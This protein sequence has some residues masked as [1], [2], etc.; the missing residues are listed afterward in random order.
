VASQQDRADIG[1]LAKLFVG[2]SQGEQEDLA[3]VQ[4]LFTRAGI[5]PATSKKL[6]ER[7]IENPQVNLIRLIALQFYFEK[8]SAL[9][10]QARS[11]L[12]DLERQI[13]VA[14]W[15][16]RPDPDEAFDVPMRF[17]RGA[18]S[19]NQKASVDSAITMIDVAAREL[20]VADL[21]GTT[22]LDIG[23]GVKF[24]Q[25]FYGRKI[26]V[27]RYHGVD[28]DPGMIDFLSSAVKDERFSYKHIDVYNARYYNAGKR[29][30]ADTDLGI[31]DETFD[32]ICLFSVFTHLE[33]ADF[34]AML[35]LTRR[36]IAPSGTL[37]FTSFI[38][39]KLSRDFEDKDPEQPLLMALYR[40]AAVREFARA[41]RWS[42]NKIFLPGAQHWVVCTPTDNPPAS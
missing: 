41:A 8:I 13:E 2:S 31:Q 1:S 10:S 9:D 20:G 34:Q 16:P 17:R 30:S 7:S 4:A 32:L 11:A 21:S 15:P 18:F 5:I 14:L 23:C 25:A 40:E 26:P 6:L 28:V 24:T 38:D 12:R 42:V 22:I 33:P 29:L 39:N 37:I 36:Y 35:E 19:K 3:A 27:K